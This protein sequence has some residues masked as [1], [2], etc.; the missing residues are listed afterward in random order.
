MQFNTSIPLCTPGRTHS[1]K[2]QGMGA[3]T[4]PSGGNTISIGIQKAT[5]I[6]R[7]GSIPGGRK[8]PS[9]HQLLVSCMHVTSYNN[10]NYVHKYY[11][12]RDNIMPCIQL[13]LVQLKL[14]L[15][16][17][18]SLDNN[19]Q[20]LISELSKEYDRCLSDKDVSLT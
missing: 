14:Y 2:L 4:N 10:K 7:R 9:S 3:S 16:L 19:M 11:C 8:H 6:S 15:V 1:S 5:L 20:E 18:N 17:D 12:V 13:F